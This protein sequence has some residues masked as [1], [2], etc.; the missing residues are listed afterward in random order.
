V[1]SWYGVFAPA[2]TPR[3]V[4]D[5]VNSSIAKAVAQPDV[6]AKLAELGADPYPMSP[7]EFTQLV[8]RD[9]E[10]WMKLIRDRKLKI[11]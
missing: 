5:L 1:S 4:I 9:Q 11:D 8:R 6:Q 7:E 2:G 10:R 3:P